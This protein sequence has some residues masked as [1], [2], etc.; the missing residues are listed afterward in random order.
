MQG[1]QRT[2]AVKASKA[3]AQLPYGVVDPDGL[4]ALFAY[5][6]QGLSL[7]VQTP[8]ER[9]APMHAGMPPQPTHPSPIFPSIPCGSVRQSQRGALFRTAPLYGRSRRPGVGVW[10][11]VAVDQQLAAVAAAA[12]GGG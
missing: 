4:T 6:V 12:S 1:T 5:P 9:L 10:P 3:C 7:H 11:L 8:P 2:S